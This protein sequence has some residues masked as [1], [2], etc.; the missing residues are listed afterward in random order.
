ML[1]V[2]SLGSPDAKIPPGTENAQYPLWSYWM[3]FTC[4]FF[5][6]T[7]MKGIGFFGAPAARSR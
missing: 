7:K 4:G 5:T 6:Q 3:G 1:R 2:R